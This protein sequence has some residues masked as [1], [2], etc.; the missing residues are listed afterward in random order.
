MALQ[1]ND[2]DFKA[3]SN[4][5]DRIPAGLQ[6]FLAQQLLSNALWSYDRYDNPR[7]DEVRGIHD[8]IK[9]LRAKLKD[10]AKARAAS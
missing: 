1:Q 2:F 9:G 3:F 8:E 6:V 4:L 7:T 5:T 10:D